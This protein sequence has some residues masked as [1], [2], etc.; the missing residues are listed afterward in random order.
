MRALKV[1]A[2]AAVSLLL[3]ACGYNT[4]QVQDERFRSAWFLKAVSDF[5]QANS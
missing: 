4:I 3:S 5:L 1:F 2:I